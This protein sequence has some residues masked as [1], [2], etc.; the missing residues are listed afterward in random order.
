[1]PA[2]PR[3]RGALATDRFG[4]LN[5]PSRVLLS[6]RALGLGD[7]TWAPTAVYPTLVAASVLHLSPQPR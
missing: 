5:A 4:A 3:K 7:T 6:E 1:M 2:P